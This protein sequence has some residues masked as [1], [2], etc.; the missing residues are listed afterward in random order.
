MR[1]RTPHKLQDEK[2]N[3]SGFS[4]VA[5]EL[6]PIHI[7]G[8]CLFLYLHNLRRLILHKDYATA[9][10]Y[11][12]RS[13]KQKGAKTVDDLDAHALHSV[14]TDIQTDIVE[15]LTAAEHFDRFLQRRRT[16]N[17]GRP[18][19]FDFLNLCEVESVR[20]EEQL[21]IA[22]KKYGLG[23]EVENYG[24]LGKLLT[25]LERRIRVEETKEI[26]GRKCFF[27]FVR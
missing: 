24:C 5:V 10:G 20:T 13:Y 18:D 12:V 17:G 3:F 15:H 1:R 27:V 8:L 11:L 19:D 2:T 25:K 26:Q 6:C 7:F 14:S 23:R 21:I 9:L 16:G 22:A 4:L